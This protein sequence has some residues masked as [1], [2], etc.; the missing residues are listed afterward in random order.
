MHSQQQQGQCFID[1]SNGS[2]DIEY[3]NPNYLSLIGFGFSF[4]SRCVLLFIMF[5]DTR[6]EPAK[7][8]PSNDHT[9]VA[10]LKSVKKSLQDIVVLVSNLSFQTLLW[11]LPS[12]TS[13]AYCQVVL[14]LMLIIRST[15]C[16]LAC[17]GPL[18]VMNQI[19]Y[20]IALL[21]A[22]EREK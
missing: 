14:K 3:N 19:M 2:S 20:S 1:C 6:R 16:T 10:C 7:H 17:T 12:V 8:V 22:P 11:I 15:A 9:I 18:H 5:S 13:H 21:E 4:L